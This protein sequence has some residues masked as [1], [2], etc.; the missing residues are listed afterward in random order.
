MQAPARIGVVDAL[1]GFAVVAIMLLHNIEHFDLY[2]LPP[3]L[4]A[5]LVTLDKLVWDSGFFLFGGKAYAIFALLF[6]LT[7]H[8]QLHRRAQQG[9]DFRPRFAWRM[10]LL[11]G[12]GLVNTLFYEGDILSIYAVVGLLLIPFAHL[13]NAAVLAIASLLMLQPLQWFAFFQG[14]QDP[15]VKLGDPASWA[16][17]ARTTAYLSNGS[18]YEV[19][20]GNLTTGKIAAVRWSWENGRL[21]QMLA[22]FLFGMLAGRKGVFDPAPANLR[23]WKR[24]LLGAV[25]AFVPLY[26]ANKGLP[27]AIASEAVRRPLETIATSWSNVAFMLVL[28]ASFVLLYQ[29][30]TLLRIFAPLGRMSLTSYVMQSMAGALLYYGYG[31]GLYKVTGATTC[32]AIGIALALLQGWFSA[33]WLRHHAQGPLEGLW[34]RATWIG[35]AHGSRSPA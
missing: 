8:L 31:L 19:W 4:P 15:A 20:I 26:L 21:F 30:G 29:R 23:F 6:G 16:Y 22:L 32:L 17:F 5:W 9:I 7:F 1:R 27:A 12:F 25:T 3:G 14:L 13:S 34:H 28:V 11:L 10:A 2:H 18:M 24:I 33:W 35:R